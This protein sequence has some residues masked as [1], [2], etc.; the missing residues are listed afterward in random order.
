MFSLTILQ[1][2]IIYLL[3]STSSFLLN[4]RKFN[5]ISLKITK[6]IDHYQNT[7]YNQRCTIFILGNTN[8]SISDIVLNEAHRKLNTKIISVNM[9]DNCPSQIIPVKK[10]NIIGHIVLEV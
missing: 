7:D 10:E 9:A 2:L 3:T 8:D 5:E 6:I 1:V 4:E